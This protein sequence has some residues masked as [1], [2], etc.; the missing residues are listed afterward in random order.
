MSHDVGLPAEIV[1]LRAEVRHP[2]LETCTAT[3]EIAHHSSSMAGVCDGQCILV[4][5]AL[6]FGSSALQTVAEQTDQGF[7]VTGR[8]RWITNSPVADW[9]AVL[10]RSERGM[11]M[12]AVDLKNTPGIRIGTPDL[13]MGHRGQLTADIAFTDIVVTD[14][15]VPRENVLGRARQWALG[16]AVDADVRP[17]RHRRRGRGRRPGG[18]RSRG[19]ADAHAPPSLDSERCA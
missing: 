6:S 17:H 15:V 18:P 12:L 14:V 4:P 7:V 13:K 8:K 11:T 9:V 1:E 5:K 3:E 2:L 19:R 16:R 10:C